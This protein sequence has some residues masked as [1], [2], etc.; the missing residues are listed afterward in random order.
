MEFEEFASEV[1]DVVAGHSGREYV[2]EF[3]LFDSWTASTEDVSAA[4]IALG[5]RLP[6][7]YRR[8]MQVFGGGVFSFVDL[9]PIGPVDGRAEDLLSVN[10][11]EF[12]IPGFVAVAPVGTGDWWG[13][14]SADGRCQEQ[15]S[16]WFHEDGTMQIDADDFLE[17]VSARGLR[18]GH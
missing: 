2:P 13:F 16:L 17:F 10:Q 18:T 8:F 7:K 6:E 1:A 11:G 4:E 15:V 5:T 14:V 12:A 9:L 3:K